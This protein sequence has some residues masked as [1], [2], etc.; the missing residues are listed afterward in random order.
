MGLE[1]RRANGCTLVQKKHV[2]L[3][4]FPL[5]RLLRSWQ[6]VDWRKPQIVSKI[7]DWSI[8][9]LLIYIFILTSKN[10]YVGVGLNAMS[11]CASP[12]D[13]RKC[14]KLEGYDHLAIQYLGIILE[15][16]GV[17]VFPKECSTMGSIWFL[18]FDWPWTF[19]LPPWFST[20]ARSI[21]WMFSCWNK[22]EWPKPCA[23]QVRLAA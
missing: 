19:W 18:T 2:E 8:Q 3:S 12:F 11:D 9:S 7:R 10:E 14:E 22:W 4:M 17:G 5:E 1:C 6:L 13:P 15:Q 21:K 23:L 20:S 16:M